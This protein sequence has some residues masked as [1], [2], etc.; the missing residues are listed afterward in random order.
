MTYLKSAGQSEWRP[1]DAIL[2]TGRAGRREP[3]QYIL[4]H[5]CRGLLGPLLCRK[6]TPVRGCHF[7]IKNKRETGIEPATFSLARR[8]STTEPLARTKQVHL[9]LYY[10]KNHLSTKNLKKVADYSTTNFS[11]SSSN[12]SN[13]FNAPSTGSGDSMSTP[14]FFSTSIG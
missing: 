1:V 4:R 9:I 10:M 13:T 2:R 8:R 14:A 7:C 12:S 11:N 5:C 3:N 6:G